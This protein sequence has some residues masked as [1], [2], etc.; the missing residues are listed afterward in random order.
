MRRAHSSA[1]ERYATG[2]AAILCVAM[3]SGL[4]AACS[5]PA[6]VDPDEDSPP[7]GSAFW[8]YSLCSEALAVLQSGDPDRA[9]RILDSGS[10]TSSDGL[11]RDLCLGRVLLSTGR[12]R[13]ALPLLGSIYLDDSLSQQDRQA[14]CFYLA[15][16]QQQAGERTRAESQIAEC[17]PPESTR[18]RELDGMA[19][20]ALRFDLAAKAGRGGDAG[21]EAA[22]LWEDGSG[23]ERTW[24]VYELFGGSDGVPPFDGGSLTGAPDELRLLVTQYTDV[25]EDPTDSAALGR[26]SATLNDLGLGG[27]GLALPEAPEASAE[28]MAPIFGAAL[29]LT[30]A[31]RRAGRAALAGLLLA[32]GAFDGDWDPY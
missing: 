1:Q 16:A 20:H 13:Q 6:T 25:L 9:T 30:G 28:P 15:W 4:L 31:N 22:V 3:L 17:E 18:R 8:E 10:S 21:R 32:E 27:Y 14:A 24:L 5:G 29:E 26:L 11:A 2:Y 12:G 7:I 23:A 19:W